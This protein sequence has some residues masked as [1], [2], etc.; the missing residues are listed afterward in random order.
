MKDNSNHFAAPVRIIIEFTVVNLEMQGVICTYRFD[1]K[2]L[3]PA[4]RDK[5]SNEY[6]QLTQLEKRVIDGVHLRDSSH[7]LLADKPSDKDYDVLNRAYNKTRAFDSLQIKFVHNYL[8]AWC[9]P[10]SMPII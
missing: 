7:G 6:K 5:G 1:I 2:W 8:Y 3:K 4:Y 9:N 10:T